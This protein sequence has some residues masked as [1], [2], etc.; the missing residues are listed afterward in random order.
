MVV[1]Q[2][3]EDAVPAVVRSFAAVGARTV[4]SRVRDRSVAV[5][6]GLREADHELVL[7]TDDDCTVA[8]SW[9][10]TAWTHL[11]RDPDA[12]V[13]GRVLAAGETSA[14]AS[15]ITREAPHDYTGE[16]HYGAL[17][18]GNMACSRSRVLELGGFDERVKVA[19]D[20]DFC[21]RWLRAGRPLR[22]EPELVIWHH[23][24]RTPAEMKRHYVAYG[25][26]QGLFYAKHLRRRDTRVVPF[27]ARDLYRGIR[28]VA[29]RIVR[30]PYEWPDARLGLLR[31]LLVG[32][33][34]GWRIF[35]SRS[36]GVRLDRPGVV[37]RS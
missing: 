3:G 26:G 33:I 19:E 14:V 27:L 1:D 37:R 30:G 25:R 10:E 17:F 11:S 13:T 2:S 23:S 31:G 18:G 8:P 32:L 36:A 24:W 28:G 9:V 4:A 21:Y 12:I 20:N 6:L 34:E 5:N 16:V 29:A 35:D 15:T 22:Y 7:V